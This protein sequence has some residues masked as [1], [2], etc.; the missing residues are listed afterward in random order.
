M[1]TNSRWLPA[2]VS[3]PDARLRLFCFPYAGGSAT[4]Y[5]HWQEMMPPAIELLPVELPGRGARTQ[6]QLYTRLDSLIE[7]LGPALLPEMELPFAFFGHSM[8]GLIAFEL[9]RWL[10]N[11]NRPLPAHLFISAK[12]CPD[13]QDE[14]PTAPLSDAQLITILKDYDGTSA[15]V[16]E[17]AEL[18]E[19]LA[20]IIRADM[21]LCDSWVS[22]PGLTLECPITVFGGLND[23]A[24][25]RQVLE[26][27]KK[28]TTNSF[29]L[30]MF[31]GGHFFIQKWG[32]AMTEVIVRQLL[33]SLVA[34]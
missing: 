29:R 32:R 33:A 25:P 1:R 17:N 15:D 13:H 22:T 26:G 31:P 3:K 30:N 7:A 19:L 4:A 2:R 20:P 28:Y 34:T 8:G 18:M 27:W 21:E 23:R 16:L 5:R 24:R 14:I 6:E 11:E 10:K 9:A 12:S